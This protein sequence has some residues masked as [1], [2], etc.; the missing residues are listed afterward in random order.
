MTNNVASD[1][2][3]LEHLASGLHPAGLPLP[4]FDT[5]LANDIPTMYRLLDLVSEQG[6]SGLGTR[7]LSCFPYPST[8][9]RVCYAVDKVIIAQE[10]LARFV[11]SI[12]PGTYV[13]LTDIRFKVMEMLD[14]K[15]VGVYGSM[16]MLV[17]FLQSLG[18]VDEIMLV[19]LLFCVDWS[20]VVTVRKSY[21][22]QE[23]ISPA[24][25]FV[26]ASIS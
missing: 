7:H 25:L 14:V 6:S 1:G 13:S 22:I 19:S 26:R 3:V 17:A 24:L 8:H 23:I 2:H 10:S 18:V 16:D 20:H 4:V 15:P 9:S 21:L 5:D 12:C 11:N